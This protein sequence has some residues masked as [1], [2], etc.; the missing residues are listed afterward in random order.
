MAKAVTYQALPAAAVPALNPD[1]LLTP[2]EVCQF[3]NISTKT[4]ER[5]RLQHPPAISY[6]R[7]R[8]GFRY[9]RGAVEAYVNHNEVKA[10]A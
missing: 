1:K 10:V 5:M 2:A 3:L 4:L 8:R 6:V 7:V 9:R